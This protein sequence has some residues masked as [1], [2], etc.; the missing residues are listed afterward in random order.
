MTATKTR[1]SEL[2]TRN[3][4]HAADA[5]RSALPVPS[6]DDDAGVRLI[7]LKHIKPSPLNPRKTF[8]EGQHAEMTRS[9]L[10]HGVLQPIGHCQPATRSWPA[11]GDFVG[12]APR[13]CR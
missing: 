5:P 1:N 7:P 3:G 6:L 13:A 11:S 4:K 10:S 12:L 2:G 8:D 9:I